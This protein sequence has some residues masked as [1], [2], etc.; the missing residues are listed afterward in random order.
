VFQAEQRLLL[1]F[2]YGGMTAEQK[3]YMLERRQSAFR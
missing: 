1:V 2:R 3:M